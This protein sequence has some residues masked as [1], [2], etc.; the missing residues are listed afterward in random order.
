MSFL[1]DL[2]KGP[3]HDYSADIA[4]TNAA[5]ASA[6]AA[7]DK[8]DADKKAQDLAALRASLPASERTSASS[9]LSNLGADP[10]QYSSLI[11]QQI[12]DILSTISPTDPNPGAYFKNIGQTVADQALANKRAQAQGSVTGEFSPNYS[13]SHITSALTDPLIAS[14][15]ASQRGNADA[16]IQ[17]MLKR[18]VITPTGG[19]AATRAL[20]LQAPGVRNKLY[21]AAENT[22]AT[23]RQS[24]DDIINNALQTAGNVN[25][26]QQ[27]DPNFYQTQANQ[28]Q[29]V[30]TSRVPDLF[31]GQVPGNLFDTSGLAAI[32]GAG[33]GAQ[34]L[35][36]DPKAAAGIN[37]GQEDTTDPN[38][39]SNKS[40]QSIF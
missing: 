37:V 9:Y 8:A 3:P 11:D 19:E 18:G 39:P 2:F 38:A 35:K 12:N 36:F 32:A 4:A 40:T 10:N 5:R 20:E 6:Q 16:I 27:F 28:A 7:Q 31:K 17:N 25:L 22:L 23:G 29:D 30:F 33:Q 34:N 26:N 24:I 15:Y 1:T 14:E 21:G 13:Q